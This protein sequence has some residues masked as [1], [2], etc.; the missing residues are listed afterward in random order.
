MNFDF[1]EEQQALREALQKLLARAATFEARKAQVRSAAPHSPKLWRQLAEL[2][3]LGVALPEEHGGTG[4]TAVDTLVVCEALGRA[5]VLEPYIACAVIGAGLLAHAGSEAQ[6]ERLPALCAGEKLCALAH[7]ERDARYQLS[8]VTTTARRDGGDYL[9]S[10]AKHV[11][12][13]GD[14]ADELLVSA[15]TSGAADSPHGISLFLLPADTPGLSRRSYRTQDNLGAADLTLAEVRAPA[16]ALVGELDGG[17]AAVEH[18]THL[19]L[20]ALC[21][22]AVG[23][24][25]V[26]LELTTDYVKTRKQFGVPIGS[27]QA[28]QHRLA[29]MLMRLEQARSMSYLAASE[30]SAPPPRDEAGRRARNRVLAAAKAMV[31]QCGRVVG[32]GA[33]QLHGGIGMTDEAPVSHYFKRVTTLDLTLGDADHHVAAFSDL[34]DR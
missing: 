1:S 16:S 34:M 22:E 12:L 9:L 25:A 33:I 11:V 10:G 20:A 21:A 18:A 17:L 23:T 7:G 30:L 5:L 28:L 31:G 8:Y 6:R 26:L 29:D 19:G 3:A 2:G 13:G 14:A 24:M 32:Q 4:G 15:R 27:F